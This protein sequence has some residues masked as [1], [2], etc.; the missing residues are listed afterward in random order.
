[1]VDKLVLFCF[2]LGGSDSGQDGSPEGTLCVQKTS[3]Y[4]ISVFFLVALLL[5]VAATCVMFFRV[6]RTK[7]R[8]AER[9][10]REF[11]SLNTSKVLMIE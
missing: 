6:R 8:K 9:D 5:C 10:M 2:D 11:G 4:G 1:M 3:F 7:L